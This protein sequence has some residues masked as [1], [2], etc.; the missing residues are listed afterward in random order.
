MRRNKNF[1]VYVKYTKNSRS[2]L[3]NICNRAEVFFAIHVSRE[4][5]V[6]YNPPTRFE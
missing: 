2:S 1:I 4:T 6:A 3:K 5:S